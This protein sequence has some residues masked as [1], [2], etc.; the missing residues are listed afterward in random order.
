M[1]GLFALGGELEHGRLPDLIVL[2]AEFEELVEDGAVEGFE[3]GGGFGELA[4]FDFGEGVAE[5]AGLFLDVL[6]G[7]SGV[8]F[9]ELEAFVHGFEEGFL[10]CGVGCWGL[11]G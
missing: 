5:D 1:L 8:R 6:E 11:G 10:R 9:E 3:E 7:E 2:G 4:F